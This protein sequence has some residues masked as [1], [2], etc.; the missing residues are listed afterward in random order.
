MKTTFLEGFGGIS[1]IDRFYFGSIDEEGATIYD[2]PKHITSRDLYLA[3]AKE[4]P[5]N[6]VK[7]PSRVP[8]G[9][10]LVKAISYPSGEPA[11]YLVSGSE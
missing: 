7:D 6:L 8:P 4:I 3:V 2:L 1:Y 5:E 11:F 10:K 9:L